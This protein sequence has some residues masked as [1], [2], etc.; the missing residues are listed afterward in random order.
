MEKVKINYHDHRILGLRAYF[1][2]KFEDFRGLNFEIYKPND[3][4]SFKL[5]SCSMSKRK[6]LR[7][8][9]GDT[10][11]DKLIQCLHGKIQFYVIDM[12]ETSP[13]YLNVQLW[14]LDSRF[15][16]QILVP[17]GVV[18][19]HLCLS[20]ECTFFYKWS[21]GYVPIN[22]QIHVKWND[23]RFKDKVN[24]IYKNPILSDRDK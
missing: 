1:P 3:Y 23:P 21:E 10:V 18:N 16:T 20:E 6:V 24:W 19:A 17:A 2:D 11:N 13:T 14:W 4:P 5:D 9:H 22:Q 15:P 12:R 7:G 8:F